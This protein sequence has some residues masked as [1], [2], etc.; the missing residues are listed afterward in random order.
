MLTN[1]KR[2]TSSLAIY[3]L[4]SYQL[5]QLKKAGFPVCNISKLIH[6][7]C[8]KSN[9]LMDDVINRLHFLLGLSFQTRVLE[10]DPA[11]ANKRR[12]TTCPETCT[13]I[14][15]FLQTTRPGISLIIFMVQKSLN[16]LCCTH[17]FVHGEL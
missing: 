11:F 6:L 13:G 16:V 15:H 8:G 3:I 9:F 7:G 10:E 5:W 14:T 2:T 1:P 4:C 17:V 12:P